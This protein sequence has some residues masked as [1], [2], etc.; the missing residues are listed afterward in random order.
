MID[1]ATKQTAEVLE[2]LQLKTGGMSCSFCSNAIEHGLGREN[3][4]QEVH[5]SLAHGLALIRRAVSVSD[6]LRS[7]ED[8][9]DDFQQGC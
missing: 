6:D 3:G 1:A 9:G 4:V 2:S 7:I 5:I 8:L